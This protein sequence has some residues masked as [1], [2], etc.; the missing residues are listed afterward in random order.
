MCRVHG[1][2]E[3]ELFI[4]Q[5]HPKKDL[6]PVLKS[7]QRKMRT[8]KEHAIVIENLTKKYDDITAVDGLSL[9]AS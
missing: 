1:I 5:H 8:P 6:I 2:D 3:T 4:K 9:E 7:V